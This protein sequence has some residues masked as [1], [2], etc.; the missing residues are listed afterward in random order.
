MRRVR[1]GYIARAAEW[2]ADTTRSLDCGGGCQVSN[3]IR[4]CRDDSL[5]PKT[6]NMSALINVLREGKYGE[7]IEIVELVGDKMT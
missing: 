4:C 6:E 7:T 3:V 1:G 5:C 2:A